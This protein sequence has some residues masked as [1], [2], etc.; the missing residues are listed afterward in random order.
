QAVPFPL[1]RASAARVAQLILSFYA[2]RYPGETR[3]QHQIRVTYDE[4]SNT[5]FVQAS[6]TDLAEIRALVERIDNTASSAVNDLRVVLLKYATSDELT[7]L[8]SRAIMEGPIAAGTTGVG[9]T[10]GLGQ[11]GGLGQLGGLGQQGGLG[12]LGGQTGLTTQSKATSLRFF[13][14]RDKNGVP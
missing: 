6:P 11:Q 1:K 10:G 7:Y 3:T 8:L 9:A 5:V 4:T 12:Q 2:D 13:S 14:G